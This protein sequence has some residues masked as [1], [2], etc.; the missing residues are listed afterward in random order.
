MDDQDTED[1]LGMKGA[2]QVHDEMSLAQESR[3][4]DLTP[5]LEEPRP[6]TST[7]LPRKQNVTFGSGSV[8]TLSALRAA[9]KGT[10]PKIV[11]VSG[12]ITGDGEVVD[13][14]S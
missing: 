4:W 3:D 5:A 2:F 14:G 11:K 9:V 1:E 10:S 8:T 6:R 12:I 7:T 13:V